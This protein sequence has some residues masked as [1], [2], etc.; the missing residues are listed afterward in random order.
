MSGQNKIGAGKV[1]YI[2]KVA[3][4][5]AAFHR[6]TLCGLELGSQP[7]V[8]ALQVARLLFLLALVA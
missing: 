2:R 6:A 7:S 1:L 8:V 4:S 3:A 5:E